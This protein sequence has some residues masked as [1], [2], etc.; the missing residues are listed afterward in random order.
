M[1]LRG[2][3][4]RVLFLSAV[5]FGLSGCA[6]LFKVQLA[7]IESPRDG[8]AV[9]VLVSENTVDFQQVGMAVRSIGQMSKSKAA[10]NAGSNLSDIASAFQ[11]GPRTGVPVFN[12]SYANM[13]AG[14]LNELCKGGHLGNIVSTRESRNY[15]IIS[16][17]IIRL[18]A[19]CYSR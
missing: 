17:Q 5:T 3:L 18:D 9:N 7:D 1:K 10:Q 6:A 11:F 4:P 13:V 12:D 8:K 2:S 16:G 15:P 19:T 14:Q